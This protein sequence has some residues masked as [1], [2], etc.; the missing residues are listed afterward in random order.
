MLLSLVRKVTEKRNKVW[1]KL[2][3]ISKVDSFANSMMYNV[4]FFCLRQK[5]EDT[6]EVSYTVKLIVLPTFEKA[7]FKVNART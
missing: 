7:Q 2:N 3:N 5:F 4:L 1:P 6:N